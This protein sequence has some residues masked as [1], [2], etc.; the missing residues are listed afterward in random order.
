MRSRLPIGS[1]KP[2]YFSNC[3][4]LTS[5]TLIV[6]EKQAIEEF[7]PIDVGLACWTSPLIRR[8]CSASRAPLLHPERGG[9]RTRRFASTPPASQLHP[10]P[11]TKHGFPLPPIARTP[12]AGTPLASPRVG[13]GR[14]RSAV[15]MGAGGDR[16]AAGEGKMGGPP[17]SAGGGK[18]MV[19]GGVGCHC[20]EG[21]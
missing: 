11:A 21:A 18:K 3:Q 13:A 10:A 4:N 5:T 20:W 14:A 17:A 8:H 19:E 1:P 16:P 12:H 15:R 6:G 9:G 7:F 2:K